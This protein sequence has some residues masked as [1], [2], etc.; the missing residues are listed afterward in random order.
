VESIVRE[1]Q[2]KVAK[3][4]EETKRKNE[5]YQ[6]SL[7]LMLEKEKRFCESEFRFTEETRLSR[8]LTESHDKGKKLVACQLAQ[9]I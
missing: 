2:A 4:E 5:F 7:K 3:L 1:H 6:E 8:G 9:S